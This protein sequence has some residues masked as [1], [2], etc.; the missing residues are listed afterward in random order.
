MAEVKKI[1]G[2]VHESLNRNSKQ[3]KSDRAKTL[4]EDLELEAKRKCE[5]LSRDLNRMKRDRDSMYDF[6]P[7]NSLSL[8]LAKNVDGREINSKDM[9][10][11]LK[12]RDLEIKFEIAMKRYE[13]LYGKKLKFD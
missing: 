11:S 7:D 10:Q 1:T 8:V 6:S 2:F 4:Y 3:I 9:E 13:Y 5:D 12:I